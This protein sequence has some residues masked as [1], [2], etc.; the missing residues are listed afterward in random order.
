MHRERLGQGLG[1]R[2]AVRWAGREKERQEQ[3]ANLQ[4]HLSILSENGRKMGREAEEKGKYL[5]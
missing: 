2:L 1:Q 3:N 5:K 4:G